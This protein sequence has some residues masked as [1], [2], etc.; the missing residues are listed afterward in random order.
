MDNLLK[1]KNISFKKKK[2]I[3]N[4]NVDISN[5]DI[6]NVDISNNTEDKDNSTEKPYNKWSHAWT[7]IKANAFMWLACAVSVCLFVYFDKPAT[8]TNSE[9]ILYYPILSMI[10]PYIS[11][12]LSLNAWIIFACNLASVPLMTSSCD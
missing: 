7:S 6:S 5:V 3:I 1:D 11:A 10:T 2:H 12:F 4:F 9:H 8:T